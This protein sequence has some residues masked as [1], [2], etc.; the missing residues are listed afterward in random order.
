MKTKRQMTETMRTSVIKLLFK[1]KDKR[2]IENYRPLS[3]LTADY[4]IIA[5]MMTERMKTVLKYVVGTERRGFI[6]GRSSRRHRRGPIQH[7]TTT[8]PIT[9]TR[10]RLTT[11]TATAT[12]IGRQTRKTIESAYTLMPTR[13]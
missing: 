2:R 5:K 12:D 1:K 4:K 8:T 11:S 10:K 7:S 3:L 6:F 13:Q 9:A